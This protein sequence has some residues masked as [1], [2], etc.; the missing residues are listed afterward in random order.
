MVI[1]EMTEKECR[2]I[3][4]RASFGRLGCALDNQPYVLPINF[5]CDGSDIFVLSTAG[6]KIE[7]MRANPRVCVQIDEIRSEKDW[8]SVIVNGRYQELPEP[9]FADERERARKLLRKRHLW[10]EAPMAERQLRS[11]D[12]LLDPL[13]FRIQIEAMTGLRAVPES[14]GKGG[15]RNR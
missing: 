11:G 1:K 14:S 6:Q 7:W 8:T 10:L 9:Q 2:E 15:S 4:S 5:A 3:L 12:A 13:F